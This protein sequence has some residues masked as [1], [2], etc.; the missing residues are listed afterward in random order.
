[1]NTPAKDIAEYL[2]GQGVGALLGETAWSI[3][4]NG[5][6]VKPADTITVYDTGGGHP[7]TDAL[8]IDLP[9]FQSRVRAVDMT[10]GTDKHRTIRDLLILQQPLFCAT[11]RFDLIVLVNDMG[12]IGKDTSNRHILIA[13]YRGRRVAT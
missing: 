8:D 6:N 2:A 5:E 1:M 3:N 9:T 10:E 13:N 4:Y 7:E 12:Q 11:S